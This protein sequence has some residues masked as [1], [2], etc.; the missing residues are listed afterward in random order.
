MRCSCWLAALALCA[1]AVTQADVIWSIGTRD[2]S[3][4]EFALSGRF[5]EYPTRFP[6]DAEFLVGRSAPESE[7]PFVLPGPLD[8]WAG[9]RRHT[10]RVAFDLPARPRVPVRFTIDLVDAHQHVPPVVEVGINGTA[11]YPVTVG[12]GAGD[13]SLHDPALGREQ[14]VSLIV[15]PDRWRAGRNVISVTSVSG[16]WMLFDALTLAEDPDAPR[17]TRIESLSAASTMLFKRAGDGV[18]QAVAVTLTNTGIEGWASARLEGDPSSLRRV[19]LL[20]GPNRFHLLTQP[21][22]KA[23]PGTVRIRTGGKEL[24]ARFEQR[25]ERQWTVYLAPSAHTDIGY[26]DLQ[27]NVFERHAANT[28]AALAA[29]RKDKGF[30]WN[31]EVAYQFP[32]FAKLRGAKAERELVD[33]LRKRR[34]GLSAHYLNMLTG[35]C[36]GEELLRAFGWGRELALRHGLD[37]EAASLTDVPSAV[38]TVPGLLAGAGVRYFAEGVNQYR[39]PIF[40]HAPGSIVQSP[41]WWRGLDGS[42][43]LALL[44][45]GYAQMSSLGACTSVDALAANLPGWLRQFDRPDYPATAI[46]AYGAFGDNSP[47]DVSYSRIVAEW[48]RQWAFPKLVVSRMEEF[49]RHVEREAGNRLPE[50]FGDFGGYWEDGAA[51]SAA[52]TALVRWAKARIESAERRLAISHAAGTSSYPADLLHDAW[53]NVLF[54][55]EH[56][57]GAAGSIAQPDASMTLQQWERKAAYARRAVDLASE[58][59]ALV[60]PAGVAQGDLLVVRND[61]P[62]TRDV[63]VAVTNADPSAA[64]GERLDRRAASPLQ[65]AGNRAVLLAREV[66]PMGQ[67]TFRLRPSESSEPALLRA[68]PDPWTFQTRDATLRLDPETGAI[69]SLRDASGREWV[70]CTKGRGLNEFLYVTGGEGSRVLHPSGAEPRLTVHRHRRSQA[71]V[72]EDGPVRTVVRVRRQGD[73]IAAC[74]TTIILTADGRI[75]LVNVLRK[76][77]TT[78]KEAGYFAFPFRMDR[79]NEAHDYVELPYGIVEVQQEQAP[80]ACRDWHSAVS[81][82]AVSDG[83]IC[84]TLATP[85][86]PLVTLGG[87]FQGQWRGRAP[88]SEGLLLSYVFNNYWD[89]NYKASQGGDMVF[90]YSLM[91][92]RGGF[93]PIASTRFGWERLIEMPRPDQ[94][95]RPDVWDTAQAPLSGRMDEPPSVSIA[96]G[97]A[98]VGGALRMPD[99]RLLVRVYNPGD[100]NSH[101]TLRLAGFRGRAAWLADHC[102]TAQAPVTLEADVRVV[103][104]LVPARTVQS[105]LIEARARTGKAM[106]A[107]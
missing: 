90:A 99:G 36:S 4:R 44:T 77:P 29:A 58:L 34:F 80:G 51:S 88:R 79:P 48:N 53:D 78:A 82:V 43:V 35:L 83:T 10:L 45:N 20:P 56:T 89:T 102:G 104:A 73:G 3:H 92:A 63:V 11:R 26:T 85:H 54:F 47:I 94:G 68:R 100:K 25:P 33:R 24:I 76:T 55:D 23:S 71:E 17:G 65:R 61:L 38:G 41:F 66:P 91:L 74:D 70:D 81:F 101:A 12:G 59:E 98:I 86:A 8:A 46:Y 106:A 13:A 50:V 32:L 14:V 27:E 18:R 107:N 64:V 31:L 93:D 16:S 103:K 7:W 28:D 72:L 1:S 96:E 15:A 105:I 69:A 6:R 40:A 84:A 60:A 49:F 9:S 67:A 57:W 30:R 62:W 97:Q 39:G 42:R 5:G 95:A 87:I 37:V 22:T 52:E 75:D 2:N 21:F 19:R